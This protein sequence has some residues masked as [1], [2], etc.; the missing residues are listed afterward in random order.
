VSSPTAARRK[1]SVIAASVLSGEP[2]DRPTKLAKDRNITAKNSGGPNRSAHCAT[3]GAT[4]VI[5][6]TAASAPTKEEVKAAVSASAARPCW[7]IG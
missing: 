5:R 1:P 7:A 3:S 6:M 4:K 2:R